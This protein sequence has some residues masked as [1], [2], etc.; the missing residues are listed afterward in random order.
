MLYIIHMLNMC[1]PAVFFLSFRR[2]LHSRTVASTGSWNLVCWLGYGLSE[3][4]WFDLTQPQ[5]LS[6]CLSVCQSCKIS[7]Q[8]PGPT[9]PPVQWLSGTVSP[10]VK[11][12]KYE[13]EYWHSRSTGVKNSWSYT[14]I[15]S[16]VFMTYTEN[17][18]R[19]F[20][21]SAS[22][23]RVNAARGQPRRVADWSECDAVKPTGKWRYA[24][25]PDGW[26]CT[27]TDI[28]A[29]ARWWL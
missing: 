5:D 15:L 28:T 18:L 23:P 29:F 25:F 7:K 17:T 13:T 12:P 21:K 24:V 19:C 4:T 9:Q 20:T 14:Y 11:Q 6:V 8:A 3:E 1:T 10:E 26:Y 16:Y 27:G 22:F 2:I